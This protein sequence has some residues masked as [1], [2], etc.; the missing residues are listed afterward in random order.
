MTTPLKLTKDFVKRLLHDDNEKEVVVEDEAVLAYQQKKIEQYHKLTKQPVPEKLKYIMKFG[1]MEDYD[2]ADNTRSDYKAL[3]DDFLAEDTSRRFITAAANPKESGPKVEW[4]QFYRSAKDPGCL[5]TELVNKE[6][7]VVRLARLS[8][9]YRKKIIHSE[10]QQ[11]KMKDELKVVRAALTERDEIIDAMND[12]LI[13]SH[14]TPAEVT[15]Q[16]SSIDQMSHQCA[17]IGKAFA[18]L[19]SAVV[20]NHSLNTLNKRQL[21]LDYL[22]PC[23][24]IDSSLNCLFESI[25][26]MEHVGGAIV[27][28]SKQVDLERLYNEKGKNQIFEVLPSSESTDESEIN[29]HLEV[30]GDPPMILKEDDLTLF[31]HKGG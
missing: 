1:Q 7:E 24:S 30:T 5:E 11:R 16:I 18:G 2:L 19:A 10:L 6:S 17:I 26:F 21:V 3:L 12:V 9:T 27:V 14:L 22:E 20:F 25:Y 4:L 28:P 13:Q 8:N 29:H 23:R 15:N 31:I